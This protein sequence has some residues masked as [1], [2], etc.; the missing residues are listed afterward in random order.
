ME[1]KEMT[2]EEI[3]KIEKEKLL[4]KKIKW[5]VYGVGLAVYITMI[6]IWHRKIRISLKEIEAEKKYFL[7]CIERSKTAISKEAGEAFEAAYKNI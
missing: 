6:A 2:K 5:G 1:E 4:K 3:L 7:E